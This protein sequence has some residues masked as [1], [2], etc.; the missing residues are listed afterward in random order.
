METEA[1]LISAQRT[2]QK[3][4]KVLRSH[5][6]RAKIERETSQNMPVS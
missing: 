2:K 1:S 6:I 3:L 4:E 5:Q